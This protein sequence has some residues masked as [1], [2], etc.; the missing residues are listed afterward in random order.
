MPE[1]SNVFKVGI[2]YNDYKPFLRDFYDKLV[3]SGLKYTPSITAINPAARAYTANLLGVS[4]MDNDGFYKNEID[5]VRNAWKNT[6]MKTNEIVDV[7]PMHYDGD[8]DYTTGWW[9][10]I[11]NTVVNPMRMVTGSVHVSPDGD[12]LHRQNSNYYYG[13][14]YDFNPK[15]QEYSAFNPVYQ[16]MQK[17]GTNANNLRGG[18]PMMINLNIGERN[19]KI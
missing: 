9:N 5:A 7:L 13:D 8:V 2:E 12:L 19:G 17:L 18:K 11:K 6:G 16:L 10:P 3:V 14:P 1:E 4:K 15:V